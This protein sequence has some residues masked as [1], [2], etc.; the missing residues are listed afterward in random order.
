MWLIATMLTMEWVVRRLHPCLKTGQ[1]LRAPAQA[2]HTSLPVNLVLISRGP[3]CRALHFC[4]LCKRLQLLDQF[5]KP[6][7]EIVLTHHSRSIVPP[8]AKAFTT[9]SKTAAS[10]LH[11]TSQ[12]LGIY[13]SNFRQRINVSSCLHCGFFVVT[14]KE[15]SADASRIPAAFL[16]LL[17]VLHGRRGTIPAVAIPSVTKSTASPAA[18]SNCYRD[19]CYDFLCTARCPRWITTHRWT[20][21]NIRPKKAGRNQ[22]ETNRHSELLSVNTT[23]IISQQSNEL[24]NPT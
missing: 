6:R 10:R 12:S 17:H 13:C 1:Q 8:D 5:L 14:S 9:T 11:Q 22:Q 7:P 3:A 16:A 20:P 15:T 18:F 4:L 2:G 19:C 21:Q 24:P 23:F